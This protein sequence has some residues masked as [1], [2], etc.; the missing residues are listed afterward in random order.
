MDKPLPYE[1]EMFS[2]DHNLTVQREKNVI[3]KTKGIAAKLSYRLFTKY[4][5][6]NGR[7]P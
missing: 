3:W 6:K 1:L 4:V 7:V 2:E 5:P